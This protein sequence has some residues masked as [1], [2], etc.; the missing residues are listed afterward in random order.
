MD[1]RGIGVGMSA[2]GLDF[3]AFVSGEIQVSEVFVEV[4][5]RVR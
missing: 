4:P 3:E 5:R 2:V 1:R